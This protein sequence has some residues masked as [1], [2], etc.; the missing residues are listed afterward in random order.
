MIDPRR[1]LLLAQ[2]E[3]VRRIRNRSAIVTAFIGPLAMAII[4]SVL[5][6]GASNISLVVGVVDLDDSAATQAIAR[7]LAAN[8]QEEGGSAVTFEMLASL[9]E[10]RSAVDDNDLD[11]ALVLPEG[12]LR[13]ATQ[14]ELPPV[15]VLRSPDRP[16]AGQ[17]AESVARRVTREV[18]GV[19][20][21][22]AAVAVAS[23]Q[24]AA[25][26][27]ELLRPTAAFTLAELERGGQELSTSAYY[28][29]SMSILFLFFTVSF[30]ARSLLAEREGGTLARILA[31]PTRAGSVA[32]GKT[33]AVSVLGLAGFVTVWVVTSLVFD[34]DWGNPLGVLLVMVA[35]V[36]ALAGVA[37]F[38]AS[39]ATTERLA[40]AFTSIVTFAFALIGGNFVR[41]GQ[42]PAVLDTLSLLTPNGWSL[43]AF[44]DLSA[45]AASIVSVLGSL[46]ILLA[47]AV[48]FGTGGVARSRR[49]ISA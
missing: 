20:L 26:R 18:E 46:G 14:G 23:G 25:A 21:A 32:L 41:P 33:L 42:G 12:F 22:R 43:R 6:G 30:A 40:D 35:T 1:V 29:A 34:A 13:G 44:T 38:I 24:D 9:D 15:L 8:E 28:G 36:L 19:A 48:V 37:T 39:L 45:D 7:E 3:I 47:F 5:V 27:G 31:T 17:V 16:I 11:A 49:L 10:A 2:N 4:F